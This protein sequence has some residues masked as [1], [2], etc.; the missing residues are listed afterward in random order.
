[1]LDEENDAIAEQFLATHDDFTLVPMSTVLAEQKIALEMG[2]YLKLLP[3]LH[4]T[5]GFFA[6]VFERKPLP[7]R[8]P[9]EKGAKADEAS[10]AASD[11][12][13]VV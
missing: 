12:S 7:A 5:D 11:E 4:Q 13:P 2:D 3:H 10:D 1:M 8:A 9:K 6:A